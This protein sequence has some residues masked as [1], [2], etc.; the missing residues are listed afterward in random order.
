M[1][2]RQVISQRWRYI[3]SVLVPAILS[4]VMAGSAILAFV[5][6]SA[7]NI[8][9][10]SL[11]RQTTLARHV[12]DTQIARLP[13]EQESVTIWD[14]SIIH[15][16]MSLDIPWIDLN[17]GVWMN[18]FFGHDEVIILNDNDKPV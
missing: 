8:D 16:K 11:Q 2:A 15:T 13:H 6:W 9:A 18:N 14:D 4:L 17:L 3:A 1:V 10:R 7:H 12:V 5:L